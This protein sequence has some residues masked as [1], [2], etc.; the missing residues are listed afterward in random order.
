MFVAKLLKSCSTKGVPGC[1]TAKASLPNVVYPARVKDAWPAKL[2][3]ISSDLCEKC[4]SLSMIEKIAS[5]P[6]PKKY[7]EPVHISKLNAMK[8]R[9]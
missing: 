6:Y 8:A 1:P 2:R 9:R 4:A 3:P 5:K 7:V